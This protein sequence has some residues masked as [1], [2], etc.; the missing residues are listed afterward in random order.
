MLGVVGLIIPDLFGIE[1]PLLPQL[2]QTKWLPVSAFLLTILSVFEAGRLPTT[3]AG[4]NPEKRVYP[5]KN[6]D[7]LGITKKHQTEKPF[8]LGIFSSWVGGYVGWLA[9]GWWFQVG[10]MTEGELENMKQKELNNGRLAMVAFLGCYWASAI[11]GQG[12]ITMLLEHIRDPTTNSVLR[13]IL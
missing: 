11:T 13:W 4:K 6:F 8:G 5:G 9:G 7:F 2:A 1:T 3:V 12:P 10:D